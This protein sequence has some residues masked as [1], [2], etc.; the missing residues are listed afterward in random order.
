LVN[1]R[2]SVNASQYDRSWKTQDSAGHIISITAIPPVAFSWVAFRLNMNVRTSLRFVGF[3]INF[4]GIIQ[5]VNLEL[6]LI[7]FSQSCCLEAFRIQG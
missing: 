7:F 1:I 2:A 6:E 4:Y 5:T 3:F